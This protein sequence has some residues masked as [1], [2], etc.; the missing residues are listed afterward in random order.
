MPH[1]ERE[2]WT[3]L[4]T[5]LIA[6]ALFAMRLRAGIAE[7]WFDGPD[8]FQAWGRM[9]LRWVALSIG[10]AIAVAI[11]A[12]L[13]IPRGESG[14]RV[15]ERDR[16]IDLHALRAAFYVLSFGLLAIIG[17]LALGQSVFV[18][19]NAVLLLALGAEI[20]RSAWKIVAYRRDA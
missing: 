15:D 5:T 14:D 1:A 12:S 4:A 18:A 20:V 16:L 10:V 6:I 8:A 9:V 7:G 2:A 3:E 17:A 13:V 19:M 11:L